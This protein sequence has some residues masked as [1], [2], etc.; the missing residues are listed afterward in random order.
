MYLMYV[1]E[2]GDCGIAGSRTRY[3][4]LTGLVIHELRWQPYL[5]QLIDFR[6]RMKQQFGLSLREEI[7]ASAFINR[8][9]NLVS[10]KRNDR[11]TIIR[12]LADELS[13]MMDLNIINI[14]VINGA[15]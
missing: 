10:I 15:S 9:G 7:H 2:S 4:V 12:S 1:D 13:T 8:P 5:N 14:V 3:F 6:R 11:L